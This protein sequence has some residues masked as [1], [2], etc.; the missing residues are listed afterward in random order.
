MS[1]QCAF[2]AKSPMQ[3]T[4]NASPSP[5]PVRRAPA[6]LTSPCLAGLPRAVHAGSHRFAGRR[7]QQRDPDRRQR[8]AGLTAR[9]TDIVKLVARGFANEEIARRLTVKEGTLKIHL[10]NIYRK[11]NV[12]SRLNLTLYVQGKGAL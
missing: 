5:T 7:R 12:D 11:L 6:P 3:T 10:H 1:P 9:E 8:R 2:R 4:A